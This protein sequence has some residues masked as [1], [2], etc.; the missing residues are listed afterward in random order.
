[1]SDLLAYRARCEIE[2]LVIGECVIRACSSSA[3]ASWWQLWFRVLRD[4]DGQP[5]TFSVPV[6]PSG[7]YVSDGP[8]G[9][10]WGLMPAGPN[11]WQ[12]SPSIN[13]LDTRDAHAGEH[14]SASLWHHTPMLVGVPSDARWISEVP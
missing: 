6:N 9:K 8:G 2:D 10:T 1:M 4:G 7:P 3:A 12:I 11:Q 13:V 5:D 14:P